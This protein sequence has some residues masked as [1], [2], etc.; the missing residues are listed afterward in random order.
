MVCHYRLNALILVNPNLY[1]PLPSFPG[2][3]GITSGADFLRDKPQP[4][5]SWPG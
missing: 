1:D 4:K 3:G 5:N 2:S